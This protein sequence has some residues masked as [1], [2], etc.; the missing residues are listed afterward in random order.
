[1]AKPA[2][3]AAWLETPIVHGMGTH[4]HDTSRRLRDVPED[5]TLKMEILPFIAGTQKTVKVGAKWRRKLFLEF[6]TTPPSL[7]VPQSLNRPKSGGTY[8]DS[9]LN[10]ERRYLHLFCP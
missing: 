2:L 3:N 6:R 10:A 4:A 9:D 1:M 5:R 8:K 7:N